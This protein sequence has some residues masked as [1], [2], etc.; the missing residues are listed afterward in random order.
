MYWP[1]RI[2]AAMEG[3]KTPPSSRNITVF[4]LAVAVSAASPRKR[5]TQMELTE[6]LSDCRTF[7]NRIGSANISRPRLIEPWVRERGR[8]SGFLCSSGPMRDRATGPACA[9][10]GQ[11]ACSA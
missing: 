1:T 7:P 8:I 2:V 6:P 9:R 11:V 5:P 4:A 10:P 3:P